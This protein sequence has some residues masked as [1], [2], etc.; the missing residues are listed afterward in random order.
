MQFTKSDIEVRSV[1]PTLPQCRIR[2]VFHGQNEFL[3][4]LRPSDGLNGSVTFANLQFSL[5]KL[6]NE[7]K[8]QY[9][10]NNMVENRA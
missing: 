1:R 6:P 2:Q 3:Y 5:A 4:L 8:V 7:K 9:C 10:Y